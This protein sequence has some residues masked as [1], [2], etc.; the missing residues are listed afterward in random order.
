MNYMR[1][2]SFVGTPYWMAPEVVRRSSYDFKADIWSLGITVYEMATGSPPYADHEPVKAIF[3]I[4]RNPP[5]QLEGSEFSKPLQEFVSLCLN[6]VPEERPNADDLLKIRFIKQ[7][8]KKRTDELV[9]LI[10]RY[11][12]WRQSNNDSDSDNQADDEEFN[13]EKELS[14]TTG[15]GDWLFESVR[16][17]M[18]AAESPQPDT[19]SV[20]PSKARNQKSSGDI[21][22]IQSS[23]SDENQATIKERSNR[24]AQKTRS[25][26]DA[27]LLESSGADTTAAQLNQPTSYDDSTIKNA[28][29]KAESNNILNDEID[30]S[31]IRGDKG[32]GKPGMYFKSPS[33]E[34]SLSEYDVLAQI[35]ESYGQDVSLEND[36]NQ[37]NSI[38]DEN[39]P[40]E[41]FLV[42]SEATTSKQSRKKPTPKPRFPVTKNLKQQASTSRAVS[43]PNPIYKWSHE[44]K[45]SETASA[46]LPSLKPPR[47]DKIGWNRKLLHKNLIEL[48]DDLDKIFEVIISDQ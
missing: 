14:G 47:I 26:S 5:A 13:L 44:R 11:T 28:I 4:P 40:L 48:F 36:F 42:R 38:D 29:P 15:E 31:T 46:K 27:I 32:S 20:T 30:M 24:R 34:T 33:S 3:L 12:K 18:I 1:R 43:S 6:D 21:T 35:T 25:K 10:H 22:V 2:H 9:E 23:L 7:I 16:R 8:M 41:T 37:P 39:K 19:A 45:S 17:S